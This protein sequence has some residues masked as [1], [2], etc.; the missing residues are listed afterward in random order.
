MS[1]TLRNCRLFVPQCAMLEQSLMYYDL[2]HKNIHYCDGTNLKDRL[3]GNK[4]GSGNEDL[5]SGKVPVV[6]YAIV[7]IAISY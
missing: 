4:P 3:K 7:D 5:E 2:E 6:G 1:L